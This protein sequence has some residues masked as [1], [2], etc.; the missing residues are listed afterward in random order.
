MFVADNARYDAHY[1]VCHH[2]RRQFTSSEHIVSDAYLTGYEMLTDAVVYALVVATEN[3]EVPLEREVV[4]NVL[5]ELLPVG[6][7]VYHLVV[8]AFCLEG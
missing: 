4:G 5:V 2:C 7:G 1:R 3:N 6:R 8:V